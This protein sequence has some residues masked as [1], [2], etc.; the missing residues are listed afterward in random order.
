[1]PGKV[2][3]SEDVKVRSWS[4]DVRMSVRA[5]HLHCPL[6]PDDLQALLQVEVLG[7]LQDGGLVQVLGQVTLSTLNH[8]SMCT[9]CSEQFA[10]IPGC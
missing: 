8:Y 2:R 6:L 4:G 7:L 1:M 5:A 9:I 3:M 10:V